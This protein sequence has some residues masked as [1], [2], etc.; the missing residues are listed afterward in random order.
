[1]NLAPAFLG[2]KLRDFFF[3]TLIG[4]VPGTLIYASVGN[5]LRAAFDAGTATDPRQAIA[6]L[7]LSPEF[8]LPIAGLIALS[9]L[10]VVVRTLR[11]KGKG[12][13]A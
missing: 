6:R 13:G 9:L 2:V 4:I 10:P 12:A 8:L 3:A 5:G 1:V 7:I 11:R